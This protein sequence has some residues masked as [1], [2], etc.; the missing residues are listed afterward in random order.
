MSKSL[1]GLIEAPSTIAF[2]G[3]G[4]MGRP[5]A[6]RLAGAGFKVVGFDSGADA[7]DRFVAEIHG[8][9]ADNLE[10]AV[11]DAAAVITM[12]P[13]GKIVRSVVDALRPHLRAGTVILDMSSSEPL[14]T[15]D[16]NKELVAAGFG[17][18]DAP[19]SGGVKRAV[20]GSLAI[21]AG[22]ADATID[23]IEPILKAMGRSIFRTGASGS[24]HAMKA[25]NNYVSGAGLAAA[26]EALRIGGA[27]GLDPNVMVDVLNASTGRNNA[28]DVKLKQFVISETYASGFFIGLMAKDIRIADTLAKQLGIDVPLADSTADLWD[29]AAK[30][31]GAMADHTEIARFRASD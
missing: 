17:L 20:D 5:M 25:L 30:Q 31:L 15:R 8:A 4:N 21:M 18:V 24:G 10:A 7:R 19:V 1:Q 11:T 29:E 23:R 22:G 12:L 6:A 26:V 13:T 28:T 9:V 27:F 14:G 16:L 2:I 3:L